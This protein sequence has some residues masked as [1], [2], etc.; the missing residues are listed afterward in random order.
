LADLVPGADLV[1]LDDCGHLPTLER[2]DETSGALRRRL[3]L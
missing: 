3:L 1:L 2:P